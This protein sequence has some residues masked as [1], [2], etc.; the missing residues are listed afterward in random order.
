MRY[1]FQSEFGNLSFKPKI[2]TDVIKIL[3]GVNL[4]LWVLK[5]I[6][7][8]Q[9][10]LSQ[11][12]G[13]SPSTAWPMIWQPVTYMFIHG[14]FFHVAI[15]MF[16]LWM[17]GSEMETI[18]GRREFLKYYFL[19]GIGSGI[20]WL[21]FNLSNPMT[22]LIGASGA[23]YG[24][25]LA[26]G[27]MFPNRKVWLYFVVPI[28]VKWFVVFLGVVAFLS[29][30]DNTSNISHLAHLSGML[31]GYTYLKYSRHWRGLSILFRRGM[32]DIRSHVQGRR[33]KKRFELKQGVDQLL[34]KM[35]K[36]GYDGLSEEEKKNL[37]EMSK[38]LS[39]EEE[40]D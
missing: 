4:G 5:I 19:T 16:V 1:Q 30:L 18:W 38:E 15:N 35:N 8:S 23:V 37:F 13:L 2:F 3:I 6:A 10:D 36:V 26:Y 33:E 17:F 22:I 14:S 40:K 32:V 28:K 31:I 11:V 27:L 20:V 21:L 12:F 25:L 7:H 39:A 34:D 24:V 29:S 9:I